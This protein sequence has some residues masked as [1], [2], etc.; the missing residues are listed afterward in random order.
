MIFLDVISHA[1]NGTKDTG[2]TKPNLKKSYNFD[3]GLND[4]RR[5]N[6]FNLNSFFLN[7]NSVTNKFIDI[8]EKKIN[9]NVDI[10]SI[11]ETILDAFLPSAQFVFEE[12]Q[13]PYH[14]YVSNR[15]G[16]IF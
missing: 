3:Q 2:N 16:G 14:L 1:S 6:P 15:S 9:G 11:V 13:L 12:Y 8:M 5:K 4:L 10:A 7:I